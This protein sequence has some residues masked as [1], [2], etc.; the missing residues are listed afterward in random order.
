MELFLKRIARKATYTIG[1]LYING[2]R[3]CDTI[4][5]KD[6][7]LNHNGKFDNGETKVYAQTAIPNGRYKVTMKVQ[8]P[9]FSQKKEYNW[10]KPNGK[11]GML[12]RLL[13]VPHFEGILIHCLT[14]DTEI[15]TSNGWQDLKSFKKNPAKTC[16]SF[17]VETKEIEATPITDFIERDYQGLLY[18]CE[19][20]R[21]NYAVTDKHRMYVG[22]KTRKGTRWEFRTADNL[23]C[24]MK[25]RTSAFKT[26][27]DDITETQMWFYR[28]L[29]AVQADGYLLN[30]SMTAGQVRFHL[31]KERKI[32]RIKDLITK[33]GGSFRE[34]VDCE[35]KTNI[36]VDP[37]TSNFIIEAL[38]PHRIMRGEKNLP[39]EILNLKASA[40]RELILEYLFWDGRYENYVQ[41]N[42]NMAISSTNYNTISILQAMASMCGMRTNCRLESAK[43]GCR[44]NLWDLKFFDNQEEVVPREDNFKTE[45]YDGKVWCIS[46]QNTTLIIRNNGRTMIIGN[47]G[48]SARSS[49][50]C[51]IVGNNNIV[52]QVTNSM[53]TCKKLYP[54]LWD[55]EINKGESIYIT[56]E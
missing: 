6:R 5:D 38:N 24:G 14:P 56:V 42:K 18:K 22:A 39:V 3:F 15:L 23:L 28:L 34:F 54:I 1:R 48:S 12:P 50:G 10:W 40:L 19:G 53:S 32:N 25:F 31:V 55:A 8:S 20:K 26:V 9:K 52:G 45:A 33:C 21:V 27:G 37:Q 44:S 16:F 4:E 30:W 41:N 7:D 36:T 51:I 49:A 47:C 13:N 46:N 17:N 29:M 35:G 43:D 11:Y 2:E